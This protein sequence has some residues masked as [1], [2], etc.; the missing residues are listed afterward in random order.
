MAEETA[1]VVVRRPL[2]QKI[3][4]WVVG[5]VVAL[6]VLVA[7]LLLFLNT[8]PGKKFLIRQI[9]ALKL[10]SGMGI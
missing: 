5:L 7:G 3:V 4:L 1:T 6:I 10:E 2:W 9:A 8:Q